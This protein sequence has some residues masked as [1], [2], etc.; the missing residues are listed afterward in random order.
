MWPLRLM[1]SYPQ[2]RFTALITAAGNDIIHQTDT[3]SGPELYSPG[4]FYVLMLELQGWKPL[5]QLQ[6]EHRH[7][8]HSPVSDQIS[9]GGGISPFSCRQ[10][11]GMFSRIRGSR[12][13]QKNI[14]EIIILYKV[15][16]QYHIF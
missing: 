6:A 1:R 9:Q 15:F 2:C 12:T 3:T 10:N 11:Q 8:I 5:H 4:F 14:L 7:I 13:N 16:F